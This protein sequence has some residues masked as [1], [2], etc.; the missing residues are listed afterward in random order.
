MEKIQTGL[1]DSRCRRMSR[2]RRQFIHPDEVRRAHR[3]HITRMNADRC[4][5]LVKSL[6]HGQQ[7]PGIGQ[8][9]RRGHKLVHTTLLC[10][11]N[12]CGQVCGKS[13]MPEMG[14]G[15][16]PHGVLKG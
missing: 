12:D 16:S 6:M 7:M 3:I 10:A 1:A 13:L 15:V 9:H 5:H 14:M 2:E 4:A 11:L 8:V